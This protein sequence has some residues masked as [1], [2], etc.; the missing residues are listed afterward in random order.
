MRR[1]LNSML[2][3]PGLLRNWFPDPDDEA[4]ATPGGGL[5]DTRVPQIETTTRVEPPGPAEL[6]APDHHPSVNA[7]P[8]T[9]TP[10]RRPDMAL[11]HLR[12]RTAPGDIRHAVISGPIGEVCD[13]LDQL[14][15]DSASSTP[16]LH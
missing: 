16:L 15:A 5:S 9:I 14:A 3:R 11:R 10:P 8:T 2:G 4:V 6:L 7:P 13:L 1:W 12:M